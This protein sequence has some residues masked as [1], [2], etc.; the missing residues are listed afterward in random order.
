MSKLSVGDLVY[1]RR[2]HHGNPDSPTP[3][4]VSKVGTKWVW[5]NHGTS[6]CLVADLL[7]KGQANLVGDY[8]QGLAFT[9]REAHDEYVAAERYRD[10]IWQV[11]HPSMRTRFSA[12]QLRA[13]LEALG[14]SV[15]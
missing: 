15:E 8:D 5:L 3:N 11:T 9:T 14:L 10:R 6:R 4:R 7:G 1:V 2:F 12:V 13:A